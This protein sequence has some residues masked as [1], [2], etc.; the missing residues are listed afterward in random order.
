MRRIMIAL[1]VTV[2]APT[3][4][5]ASTSRELIGDPEFAAIQKR[6]IAPDLG[7]SSGGNLILAKGDQSARGPGVGGQKG[8]KKGGGKGKQKEAKDKGK[9]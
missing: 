3:A 2:L 8:Q 6:Q 9:S 5:L 1:M 4:V 7:G